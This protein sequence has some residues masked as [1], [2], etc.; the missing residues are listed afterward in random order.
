M[1][2]VTTTQREP[3]ETAIQRQILE[4]LERHPAIAWAKRMNVGGAHLKGRYVQFAFTGCSDIIGQ[5]RDGRFFA[6]E[7]KRPDE[8]PSEAQMKF[9][10][11]V[12]DNGG[13]AIVATEIVTLTSLLN[14]CTAAR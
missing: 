6:C 4:L 2:T 11:Q 7:V 12:S 8:R 5:L 1:T 3:L 14:A 9:L 10:R 13:V